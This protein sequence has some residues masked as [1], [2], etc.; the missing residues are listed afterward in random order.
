MPQER[1]KPLL[2]GVTGG[3]GSGKSVVCKIFE[4]LGTPVYY[5][6]SRAKWLMNNDPHLKE[7]ILEV[8][9]KESF[10]DGQL[11]RTFLAQRVFA[12]KKQ[13]EILNSL[14]H[15][16][17]AE[18]GQN[19]EKK[20]SSFKLLVKEAALL[21]ETG[22]YKQL[23]QIIVVAADLELRI[24]RVLARDPQRSRQ[25]ILQIIEKQMPQEEKIERADF[26]IYNEQQHS[27]IDQVYAYLKSINLEL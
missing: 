12:D 22:S 2:V 25:E 15:P 8:F 18:D 19:W 11:N 21:Y 5:A 6:D 24:S 27:L 20:N 14:V 10:F 16:A 26:V 17:V 13:L 23:D 1:N 9:G 7:R 4:C 3:I